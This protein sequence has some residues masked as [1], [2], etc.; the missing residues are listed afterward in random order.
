VT[1]A[2]EADPAGRAARDADTGEPLKLPPPRRIILMN[3]PGAAALLLYV[4]FLTGADLYGATPFGSS[5]RRGYSVN[6]GWPELTMAAVL[7]QVGL[8]QT[9]AVFAALLDQSEHVPGR[10]G[11]A[12]RITAGIVIAAGTGLVIAYGFAAFATAYFT[13]AR[14]AYEPIIL[15]YAI[16]PIAPIAACAVL[17]A[18]LA[19]HRRT[20]PDGGWDAF[21]AFP[22]GS[23]ITA[24]LGIL[25]ATVPAVL[26]M[27]YRL[28]GWDDA[29]AYL[30]ALLLAA[31]IALALARHVVIRIA[32]TLIL[33]VPLVPIEQ[34]WWGYWRLG[35]YYAAAV[36]VWWIRKLWVLYAGS[37]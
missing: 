10:T 36:T 20:T 37:R 2:A 21:L 26:G 28:A 3:L 22:A 34:T 15:R 17:T 35:V 32:L 7:F 6:A 29:F 27:P 24:T 25:A 12:S 8:L 4:L 23:L 1:G 33:A 14:T 11:S 13:A 19:W 18:V 31:G 30:G 16:W 5:A 9:A